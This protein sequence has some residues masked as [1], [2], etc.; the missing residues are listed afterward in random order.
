MQLYLR[1][2]AVTLALVVVQTV[3]VPFIS[4]ANTVPDVLLVWIVYVAVRQGQIAGTVTGFAAGLILDLL[5]GQFL[6]LG[7]LSKTIAGFLAGYFYNEN[8]IEQILGNTQFLIIAALASFVHNAVYYIIFVQ[9]SSV[10][11][12]TAVFQFGLLS[13]VYTVVAA[14]FPVLIYSRKTV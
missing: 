14:L 9:G 6:G 5:G 4:V 8:K 2:G 3:I 13:T 7:A 11:I 1:Y 10:S 12:F